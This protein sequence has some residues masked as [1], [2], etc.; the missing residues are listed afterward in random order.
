M[1]KAI[2]FFILLMLLVSCKKD[3]DG[4]NMLFNIKYTTSS[5]LIKTKSLSRN[6]YSDF[7][8][9]ITSLTPAHFSGKFQMLGFQDA[10]NPVDINTHMLL[11]I[12]GNLDPDDPD[13]I[14]DFS[15][16]AVVNFSP[17]LRG[18]QDDHGL[19]ANEQ[20]NFIYFY[21]DLH[22]F[23][24]EVTLPP[25]YESVNIAMFNANYCNHQYWSD[26]VKVNNVLKIEHFPLISNIFNTSN[27]WPS[28]YIFGN[29]DSTF[30]FNTEG[31]G[32]TNSVNWPYGGGTILQIIRS[33]KYNAVTINT[34]GNGE[35]VEMVTT[36]GFD[37]NDLIQIYAG[38]DNV[39]Y[40]SDDVFIYAPNFW[41]RIKV[42][43][44][45]E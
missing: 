45:V 23:Y 32:V 43:V 31:N 11:L 6:F 26:S 10:I 8:D 37:T 13:R 2:G 36:V 29:C 39:P 44:S 33:N 9:Y 34:P 28:A 40:T 4:G 21:F 22:Y 17:D 15:N 19:F 35:T 24:Q 14:A 5:S 25:Q 7:G 38:A 12:D 1:K 20:I 41:E 30:V 42:D 3:K 27:G 16:N 18:I